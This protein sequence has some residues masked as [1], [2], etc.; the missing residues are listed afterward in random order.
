M[1][2]VDRRI[3]GAVLKS[4]QPAAADR[5]DA[6]MA[7]LAA[8]DADALRQV[9]ANHAQ[10]AHRIAWR[11]LG[12]ASEAEDVVQEALLRLW[13]QAGK[14]KPGGKGIAPWLSR[15]T[16]NLCID[17][18]RKSRP[19]TGV[20]LPEQI[21]DSPGADRLLQ[22]GKIRMLTHRALLD[23]P[24]RQRAAIVLTYFEDQAN[25]DAAQMLD[26]NIK[27]FESLLLRA[28]KALRKRLAERGLVGW[29]AA[30]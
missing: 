4:S 5:D 6:L 21:D 18:M 16:A 11:M 10:P 29:E 17:R 8:R 20:E 13:Q 7:R 14:W 24:D 23:L 2:R 26:M 28:R 19:A 25:S 30:Q 1:R 22:E 15:V 27:A 3:N 9:V 12:E